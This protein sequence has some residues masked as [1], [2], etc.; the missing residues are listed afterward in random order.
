MLIF[1]FLLISIVALLIF[2]LAV[3]IDIEYQFNNRSEQKSHSRI[4][5]LFGLVRFDLQSQKLDVDRDKAKKKR[6]KKKKR[7]RTKSNASLKPFIAMIKSEGFLKRVFKLLRDIL[8]VAEIRQLQARLGFGLGD[9]ADTGRCYGLMS[10]MFAFMFALPRV[11]FT[12]TPLFD[13]LALEAEI[14]ASLRVVPIRFF[15]AILR[16][17]FSLESFRAFKAALKANK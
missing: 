3:P 7:K 1:L 10:P 13:H 8:T 11:S 12:V 9:P 2:L 17:I 16:F 4:I 14:N 15:R 6:V 5:W